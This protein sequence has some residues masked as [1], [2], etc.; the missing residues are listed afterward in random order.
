MWSGDIDWLLM[1]SVCTCLQREVFTM[2]EYFGKNHLTW[3]HST[4]ACCDCCSKT[5]AKTAELS[6]MW[7]LWFLTL[8]S[9]WQKEQKKVYD[10]HRLSCEW[11]SRAISCNTSYSEH[12]FKREHDVQI[13]VQ[14]LPVTLKQSLISSVLSERVCVETQ[15]WTFLIHLQQTFT[16]FHH[17]C[18]N[19]HNVQHLHTDRVKKIS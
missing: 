6:M 17:A 4:L 12:V 13:H 9:N 8:K 19:L 1:L 11:L 18:T 2:W 3:L 14:L 7:P 10:Y 15:P 16:H 5:K